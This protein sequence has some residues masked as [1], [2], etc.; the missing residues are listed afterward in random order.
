MPITREFLESIHNTQYRSGVS[1]ISLLPDENLSSEFMGL[2]FRPYSPF[3]ETFDEKIDQLISSGLT[4]HW[5]KNYIN[6][7]GLKRVAGVIGPQMLTM[8]HLTIGFQI[9]LVMLMLSFIVFTLELIVWGIKRFIRITIEY[10]TVLSVL[11]GYLN[12]QPRF[13]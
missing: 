6:P 3:F 8:E 4:A 11:H 1:S 13:L 5:F 9:C 10:L 7:K 2:A 12:I